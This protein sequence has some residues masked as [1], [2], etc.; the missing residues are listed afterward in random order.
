MNEAEIIQAQRLID[1]LNVGDKKSIKE[2]YGKE[3]NDVANPKVFGK[4]F[5]TALLENKL[6][7]IKYTRIRSTGRCDEYEKL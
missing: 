1:K 7:G 6:M 5:K 3:W 4:L 2:I